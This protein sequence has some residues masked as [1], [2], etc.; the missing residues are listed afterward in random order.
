MVEMNDWDMEQEE[1]DWNIE[2]G[3]DDQPELVKNSSSTYR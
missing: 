2:D 1:D 3:W